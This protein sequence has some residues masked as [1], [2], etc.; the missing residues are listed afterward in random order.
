[1]VVIIGCGVVGCAIARELSRYRLKVVAIDKE[2][3]VGW[4]VTK[5]NMG[6][7]HPFVPHKGKY[8]EWMCLEGN[9]EFEKLAKELDIPF[10]RPG[11]LIVA[12]SFVQFLALIF[13][14]LYLRLVKKINAKWIWK[15]KLLEMEPKLNRKAKAA[16]YVPTAGV[17]DPVKYAIALAENAAENGVIFLL[18]TQVVGFEIEN[19]EIK[20]V[21]TDKGRIETKFVINAAGVYSDKIEELAG[22]RKRKMWHGKGVM[23]VFDQGL[24]NYYNHLIAPMPLR[25]DPRTKG[26]AISISPDGIPIWGPNLVEAKGKEDTEVDSSDINMI[27]KK[28]HELLPDFPVNA[29]MK[30]YAGVRPVNEDT[31][32]FVLGPTEVKGFINAAYILSPGLTASYIIAK[33]IVEILQSE[34]L[35]LVGKDDFKEVRKAIKGLSN[36]SIDEIDNAIRE[37][38]R[39]GKVVCLC[40]NVSEAEIREAIRRGAKT[41]DSIKFRTNA[42]MGRCQG[43][44]CLPEII[45]ILSEELKIPVDKVTMKGAGSEIFR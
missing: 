29:V 44:R 23:V 5:G 9:K 14:Y 19:N 39:Y 35:E 40:N 33:K 10:K 25:V 4:G 22:I 2:P 7:I 27:I 41:I 28:F 24:Q 12:L 15:K 8:K 26:G 3:D 16:I 32:D 17:T 31:W 43:S 18:N 6:V 42:C 37:N 34:G 13:A 30:Y 45:R 38:P 11:L 21:V 20:A 1:D 36:M